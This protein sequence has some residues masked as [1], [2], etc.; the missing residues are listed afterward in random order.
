M[1]RI[2]IA[3]VAIMSMSTLTF[4]QGEKSLK[5]ASKS[6]S[7]FTSDFS[8]LAALDE[9]K[10]Y[11]TEAFQDDK[12]AASAKSWNTRGD[13]LRNIADAQIKQQLIDPSFELKDL[14]SGI[15][16]VDAYMKALEL[17]TKKGDTKNAIKGLSEAEGVLNNVGIG[18]Y[19]AEQYVDAFKSFMAEIKASKAL[20]DAGQPSRLDEG[21]LRTEK[22]FFAGL[23]GFYAEDYEQSIS[24]L[25]EA[26][27]T[28]TSD[29]TL[30]Q[31]LYE[32]YNKKGNSDK[33]LAA[34]NTG[35][36]KFPED[37]GL[38]FSEI[39]YYLASG[40]LEKMTSKLE[41]AL[42]QEPDNTSVM[43]TLGQVYD[44]LHV[45]EAEAGNADQSVAYFDKALGHYNN[46]LNTDPENFD[47]NYSIGA[48]YYNKAASY[49]DALT[50]AANDFS[51]AGNKK[52]DEVKATMGGYFDQA[53][54]YFLKS[55]ELNSNDKNTL[56]A[57][58]EIYVRKD[59]F[60][61]SEVYKA[62]LEAMAN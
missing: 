40:E 36:E 53:L 3:L 37:S 33:A 48:L 12:V 44:Q 54:P 20:G 28:G 22:L 16:S 52:Y 45:K 5:K 62:R 43:T 55:D 19:N 9:A 39:N 58:K 6:L 42:E 47:I 1:K 27:A 35:R 41:M 10:A 13:I 7:K 38:L 24:T 60:D 59:M 30:Y 23:T 34:L 17:A 57:L 4:A 11:I 50:E 26:E 29:A 14:T 61:K 18:L 32:A 56:I 25:E 51:A 46:A 8:N 49:T 2:V 15:E 31:F 21:T